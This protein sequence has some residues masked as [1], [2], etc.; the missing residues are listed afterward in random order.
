MVEIWGG[1][2][3]FKWWG[4]KSIISFPAKRPHYSQ[5]L[6]REV[7]EPSSLYFRAKSQSMKVR[8]F[9][10]KSPPTATNALASK[11]YYKSLKWDFSQ[12]KT[13]Q[14]KKK[15]LENSP[16]VSPM[17]MILNRGHLA[18]PEIHGLS[19]GTGDNPGSYGSEMPPN[20]QGTE[21]ASSSKNGPGQ[22]Y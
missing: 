8:L 1:G 21:T 4:E 22:K 20:N 5:T 12:I 18:M 16:A 6:E 15:H 2:D 11:W 9:H 17:A 10:F 3:C 14:C 19:P 13:Q 7:R